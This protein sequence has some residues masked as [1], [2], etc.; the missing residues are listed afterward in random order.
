MTLDE[1]LTNTFY[2]GVGPTWLP[3]FCLLLHIYLMPAYFFK[4]S[5]SDYLFSSTF[6]E[7]LSTGGNCDYVK[8]LRKGGGFYK[9]AILCELKLNTPERPAALV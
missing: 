3:T 7:R 4:L 8:Y 5:W 6:L 1:L 9:V 2:F